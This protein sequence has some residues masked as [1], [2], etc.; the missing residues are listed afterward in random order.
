M[1]ICGKQKRRRSMAEQT[2]TTSKLSLPSD[3]EIVG[4]RIMDAPPELVFKAYTDPD[5]IPRW[6]GPRRYATT[7]D[8]MDLRPGGVWRFVHR[9]AD[10]G[11]YAFNGVYRE[12]VPPKRLVYTFNYEGAPGHEAVETVTFEEA[13][14]GKTRM[15]DHLL[16]ESREE[17]DGMLNSGMEEGGAESIERLAELLSEL[18]A[19]KR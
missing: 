2:K 5:L 13:E 12:I 8:K 16:F 1:T 3:R 10:G 14:G 15:T 6:W 11:E 19:A 9:A 17:R 18:Q 7:V 4:S